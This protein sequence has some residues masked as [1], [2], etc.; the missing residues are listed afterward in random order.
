MAAARAGV[1]PRSPE[2][3]DLVKSD[4]GQLELR[5]R[6]WYAGVSQDVIGKDA[7][8]WLVENSGGQFENAAKEM[9]GTPR[10]VAKQASHSLDYLLGLK[11]EAPENIS[12]SRVQDE[13]RA[14]A[15]RIYMKK[16]MPQLKKDWMFMGQVVTFTGVKLAENWFGNKDLASRKKALDIQ[17]EIYYK[18]FFFLRESQMRILEFIET[19]HYVQSA[20]GR[21]LRLYGSDYEEWAKVACAFLGQGTGA[22]HVQAMMRRYDSEYGLVP[23]IQVHDEL[24]FEVPKSWS[25]EYITGTF[26]RPMMEELDVI[27]GFRVP[28]EAMRGPNWKDTRTLGK[29]FA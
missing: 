27:P 17:E 22:E 5:I 18:K 7:F 4:V 9:G 20:S 24:V 2:T 3:H 16:Y 14:G 23:L 8:V 29:F 13:V 15:R 6:L 25:D 1:V 21:F 28:I 26:L 11:L 10:D 12:S 19:H